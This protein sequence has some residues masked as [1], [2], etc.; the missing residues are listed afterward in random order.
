MLS[1]AMGT[2]N[3]EATLGGLLSCCCPYSQ[4]KK[5]GG[6]ER[7][8]S[9]LLSS[10][11]QKHEESESVPFPPHKSAQFHIFYMPAQCIL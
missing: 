10:S 11:L 1:S 2:V 8:L 6:G 5:R 4:K 9:A 7:K 3:K